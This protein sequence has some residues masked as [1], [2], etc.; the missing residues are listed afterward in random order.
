MRLSRNF[1]SALLIG[2]AACARPA[3]Q[4]PAPAPVRVEHNIIPAPATYQASPA[5]TFVLQ[6]SSI[7]VAQPGEA[8]RIGRYLAGLIGTTAETT[9]RVVSTADTTR[10]VI[11]L[12]IDP[13]STLG[14]EAYDLTVT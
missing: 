6:M 12:F 10:S 14:P 11:E 9:P 3:P 4:A 5:D 7:I 2:T 8:E 1:V 13:T